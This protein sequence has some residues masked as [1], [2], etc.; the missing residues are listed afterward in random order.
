M[1]RRV[2]NDG[3]GIPSLLLGDLLKPV[4]LAKLWENALL[5]A[6]VI[7]LDV[8]Y[9]RIRRARRHLRHASVAN[10]Y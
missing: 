8:G 10:K 6:S 7:I 5:E 1:D 2:G 9:R 3:S 4:N